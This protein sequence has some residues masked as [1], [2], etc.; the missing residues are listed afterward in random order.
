M[1]ILSMGRDDIHRDGALQ[2]SANGDLTS[3]L[4][5]PSFLRNGS[6]YMEYNFAAGCVPPACPAD[7]GTLCGRSPFTDCSGMV[8]RGWGGR[9]I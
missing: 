8:L 2:A 4:Q 9:S 1:C 3:T 6:S 7:Y 5:T